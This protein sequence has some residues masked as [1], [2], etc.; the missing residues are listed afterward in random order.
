MKLHKNS[1]W[2]REHSGLQAEHIAGLM[3]SM[4]SSGFSEHQ[5]I[6][7]SPDG[8]I[9]F[10]HCRA[11][12]WV[13]SQQAPREASLE[14]IQIWLS[15]R[16]SKPEA[17]KT[18]ASCGATTDVRCPGCGKMTVEENAY[19]TK[20]RQV[21]DKYYLTSSYNEIV[22]AY[23]FEGLSPPVMIG[24]ELAA[25]DITLLMVKD[26]LN[27]ADDDVVGLAKTIYEA[28][29]NQGATLHE[30]EELGISEQKLAGMMVV[31]ELP[32]HRQ[33]M[34]ADGSVSLLTA[35][36]AGQLSGDKRQAAIESINQHTTIAAM[37]QFVK[38][39]KEYSEP[40]ATMLDSPMDRNRKKLFAA[41][42][43][44]S[45]QVEFWMRVGEGLTWQNCT[46]APKEDYLAA[47][48]GCDTCPLN[49]LMSTIQRFIFPVYPCQ[50]DN[51][52]G[53]CLRHGQEIEP[54]F[55]FKSDALTAYADNTRWFPDFETA[56][57]ALAATEEVVEEQQEP[58]QDSPIVVQ[59]QK[60]ARWMEQAQ[61]ATGKTH[62]LATRCSECVYHTEGSPVADDTVPHCQRAAKRD[63]SKMEF[64]V[65]KG[66]YQIPACH[67]YAPLEGNIAKI[68]PDIDGDISAQMAWTIL[69]YAIPPVSS[70]P[71]LNQL[72]GAPLKTTEKH[73]DWLTRILESHR[74]TLTPGQMLMVAHWSIGL[75]M[76][77]PH[78]MLPSGLIEEFKHAS[79]I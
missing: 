51:N 36:I 63:S 6:V 31:A 69:G 20:T 10:G 64:L 21:Y 72:S 29:M 46:H 5:P 8:E 56:A 59:R 57:S 27:R 45:D 70:T 52:P 62:P 30:F 76:A 68:I 25:K 16:C 58:E 26:N 35:Q 19:S 12:A 77:R 44:G 28:V 34:F 14:Q 39:I 40:S 74:K 53:Y 73:G 22:G 2:P 66:G 32:S 17:V 61:Q 1:L 79:D 37:R 23:D 4:L 15:E 13:L 78:L 75:Q 11:L 60:M 43:D 3:Y 65:S 41:I 48:L 7:V 71:I 54:P 18:C 47:G 38:N 55:T 67:G 9:R 33:R 42:R 50:G 24:D 49:G